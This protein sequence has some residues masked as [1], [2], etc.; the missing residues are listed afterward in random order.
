DTN[1][2]AIAVPGLF[3]QVHR[4][5]ERGGAMHLRRHLGSEV[6]RVTRPLGQ[7]IDERIRVAVQHRR[8]VD[9][10]YLKRNTRA[11]KEVPGDDVGVGIEAYFREV[12][13][14]GAERDVVDFAEAVQQG[15][16]VGDGEQQVESALVVG[17]Q[18]RIDEAA[19]AVVVN[20]LRVGEVGVRRQ[21]E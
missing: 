15:R 1:R 6:R 7:V 14:V 16:V 8:L 18:H 2:V 12:E 11:S 9:G 20:D 4:A 10:N 13:N 17:D 21:A 5:T 3:D 19:G